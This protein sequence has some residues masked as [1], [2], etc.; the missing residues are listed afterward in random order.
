M[1]LVE[2]NAI[3]AALQGDSIRNLSEPPCGNR[4]KAA[5]SDVITKPKIFEGGDLP[6]QVDEFC[7]YS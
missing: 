6:L 5:P 1:G 2:Q 3:L 4:G 7:R